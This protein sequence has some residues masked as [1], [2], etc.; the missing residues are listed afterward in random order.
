MNLS[1]SGKN[2]LTKRSVNVK[3]IV[4]AQ[5]IM[6]NKCK[7]KKGEIKD[8]KNNWHQQKINEKRTEDTY[9]CGR[10]EGV[11][12]IKKNTFSF[13]LLNV[14]RACHYNRRH[15]VYM[16]AHLLFVA[17]PIG[18]VFILSSSWSYVQQKFKLK[19]SSLVKNS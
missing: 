6:Y 12:E 10:I 2:W 5:R 9:K 7:I 19:H 11:K 17:I 4:N 13:I 1:R 18:F 3:M 15:L 8:K 16:N 14:A